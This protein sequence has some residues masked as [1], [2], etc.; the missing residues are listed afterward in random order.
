VRPLGSG[1]AGD[2][3]R[4]GSNDVAV[5]PLCRAWTVLDERRQH[6]FDPLEI[7]TAPANIRELPLCNGV[8]VA[9]GWRLPAAEADHLRD[10]FPREPKVKGAPDEGDAVDFVRRVEQ[11]TVGRASRFR[12]QA[13]TLVGLDGFGLD[14]ALVDKRVNLQRS[15]RRHDLPSSSP[16]RTGRPI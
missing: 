10:R 5:A 1:F 15:E 12:E 11:Q 8:D 14:A 4:Q 3:V 16:S 9:A 13:K 7:G 2:V 6:L